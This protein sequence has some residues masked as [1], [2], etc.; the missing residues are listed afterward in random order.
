MTNRFK[1]MT[2]GGA[3]VLV[4]AAALFMSAPLNGQR[5]QRGDAAPAPKKA[6]ADD[7]PVR[8]SR[9]AVIGFTK[10]AEI[11]GTPWRIHDA[12]RPQ[13]PV[14]TPAA[15][16]AM[17]GSAPSD[18]LVLFD[19]KDLSKWAH[20]QQGQQ[21]DAK[22]AV[23]DGYFEVTP[24]AGG[25]LWTR[26]KFGDVQVHLEFM[27]PASGRGN[28]QNRGNS[29]I[30]FMGLYEVQILDS[31]DNLTYADGMGGSIY[32]QHPPL[33]NASR[34]PG[35]WQ[36]YDI[37]FEAPVFSGQA[38]VKPGYVTLFWNGVLVQH[39]AQILGNTSPTMTVHR[40]AP[41]DAEM[42]FHLQDHQH[43]VRFRNIWVRRLQTK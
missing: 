28:S 19:G 13:P 18:A 12:S 2:L 33:A 37:V 41:H 39:R 14:V 3:C 10:T 30:K 6:P 27:S 16:D 32:G 38:A 9:D 43:P 15:P 23:R 17:A 22:W 11:P 20:V 4:A 5:G 29:G 35:E 8:D 25:A 7:G 24:G 40:Y 1:T 21:V 42:A 26:E 31:Y 34:K 36:T